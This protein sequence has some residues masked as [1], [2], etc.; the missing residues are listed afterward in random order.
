MVG[1]NVDTDTAKEEEFKHVNKKQC[2][3]TSSSNP[4]P[5][6]AMAFSKVRRKKNME[7]LVLG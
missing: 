4:H 6:L 1:L 7:S 3:T 5:T 2:I